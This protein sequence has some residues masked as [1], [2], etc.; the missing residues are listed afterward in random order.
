VGDAGFGR[1]V[2][3]ECADMGG[4]EGTAV[5]EVDGDAGGD[6]AN[7]GKGGISGDV[8]PSAAG[9]CD[10]WVGNAKNRR[11]GGCCGGQRVIYFRGL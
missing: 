8:M 6:G 10:V 5:G 4:D 1:K 3:R 11:R 7:V 9:V 2:E